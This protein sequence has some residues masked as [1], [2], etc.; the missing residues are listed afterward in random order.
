MDLASPPDM[1]GMVRIITMLMGKGNKDLKRFE[2]GV[3]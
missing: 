3:Q 1:D 2:G